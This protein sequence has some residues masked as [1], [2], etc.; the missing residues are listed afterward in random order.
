M[1]NMKPRRN[2]LKSASIGAFSMLIAPA[3]SASTQA[4]RESFN[5]QPN[6]DILDLYL[7]NVR[8]SLYEMG[9]QMELIP[10][11][12][13]ELIHTADRGNFRV[14]ITPTDRASRFGKVYDL[15]LM[16]EHH[17]KLASMFIGNATSATFR[18]YG[19]LIH[20]TTFQS[21]LNFIKPDEMQ[22]LREKL[23]P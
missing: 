7:V 19:I 4:D 5:V 8:S 1:K 20:M 12:P 11:E 13:S 10:G 22:K 2:F 21:A 15:T 17:N 3:L 16:D 23:D 6:D 14:K 18:K 9:T